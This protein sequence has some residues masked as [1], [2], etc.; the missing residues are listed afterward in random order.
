MD[1]G[2]N[3]KRIREF[4][5]LTQEYIATELG[6][7]RQTYMMIESGQTDVKFENVKKIAVLLDLSVNDIIAYNDKMVLNNCTNSNFGYNYQAV[8]V[9]EKE[10]YQ[11]LLTEKDLRLKQYE[12][13]LKAKDQLIDSLKKQDLSS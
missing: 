5:N 4:K 6:I 1:I 3:I 10:L 9:D 12:D 13:L 7:S 8:S 2:H 11:K